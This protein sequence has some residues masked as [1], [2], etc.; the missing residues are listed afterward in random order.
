ML[1]SDKIP[2]ENAWIV[3]GNAKHKA[4][5]LWQSLLQKNN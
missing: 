4:Q 3:W 5:A 1:A 2:D